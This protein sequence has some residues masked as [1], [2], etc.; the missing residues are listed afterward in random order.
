VGLVAHGDEQ[1]GFGA[2]A[3]DASRPS[4]P[5]V[6]SAWGRSALRL[7]MHPLGRLGSC[8]GGR[9]LVAC[10]PQRG[11]ELDR[12]EFAV[13]TNTTFDARIGRGRTIDV[14]TSRC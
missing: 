1:I 4:V 2:D 6:D 5:E 7:W 13:Q 9:D 8:A 3:V 11:G 12:A 10:V 14:S